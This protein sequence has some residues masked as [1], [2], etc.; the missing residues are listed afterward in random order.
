MTKQSDFDVVVVGG[1]PAG[2]SAASWLGRYLHR[3]ALV[4]AGDPRNWATT[5]VNGYLGLPKIRPA[6]LRKRGRIECT[7]RKVKLIDDKVISTLRTRDGRF[8]VSLSNDSVLTCD[9][10]VLAMGVKDEWPD[11]PGLDRCYGQ[12][13]H[14][15]TDCDG[16]EALNKKTVVIGHDRKAA[17]LAFLLLTWTREIIICTNGMPCTIE[18]SL[19]EKLVAQDIPIVEDRVVWTHSEG[20]QLRWL[21]LENGSQLDCEKLFFTV[22]HIPADDLGDQLGCARDDDGYIIVDHARRTSVEHVYAIGDI[23][24]GPQLAIRA[25]SDGAICAVALHRSLLPAERRL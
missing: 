4:D 13:A 10:L 8:A 25:A 6:I 9:R 23:T 24:P 22:T 19:V 14:H 21:E 7:R 1:G 17:A 15:C 3:A 5:G 12:D 16:Q 2:L 20:R 18:S 11:L